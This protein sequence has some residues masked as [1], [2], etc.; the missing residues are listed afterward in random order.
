MTL[1]SESRVETLEPRTPIVH[2]K[3]Q[4]RIGNWNVRTLYAQRKTAQAAKAMS[5]AT[6]QI[7]SRWCGSGK[8]ILCTGETI[9]YSGRDDEVYQH[10]VAIMLDKD[11]AK[12]LINWKPIDERII[13]ARFHSMYVKLTLIHA[14]A[15]TNVT[16]EEVKDHFYEKLQTIVAKTPKHDLL[17]ITG[18]LNAKV[19]S[20]VEEYERVMG[21]HGVGT[22]NDSG[23]KLCDFGGMNDVVITSAICPHK[24]I[25]KQTWIDALA[26]R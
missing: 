16:D 18:D 26:I 22:R 12:V 25:H 3:T 1:Q 13:R 14:Y 5:E 6:L 17:V 23:E 8:F 15:P 19:G 21:I 7:K 24:E 10:G 11:A 4:L 9:A 2:P 20:D